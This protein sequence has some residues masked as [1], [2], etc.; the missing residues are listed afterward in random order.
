MPRPKKKIEKDREATAERK[1]E[2]EEIMKKSIRYSLLAAVPVNTYIVSLL[3]WDW[4]KTTKFRLGNEGWFGQNTYTGGADK[5]AHM[6]AHY[7]LMRAFYNIYNYTENG[8]PIKWAYSVGLTTFLALG[9]EVGD[10]FCKNQN[11]FSVG[12]L[13]MGMTRHRD[14]V[15]A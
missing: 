8:K 6:F 3:T 10:G 7:M 13:T 5:M 9:I 1:K 14:S 15:A 11:G 2:G 4:G 12:D